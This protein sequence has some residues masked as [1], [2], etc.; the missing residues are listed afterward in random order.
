LPSVISPK[1]FDA[2]S[3]TVPLSE[4]DGKVGFYLGLQA[5]YL[6]KFDL[7]YF[8]YDNRANP[9]AVNADRLY[10]WHTKFHSLAARYL[11]DRHIEVSFHFMDGA[12]EM[13]SRLV[14]ADFIAAYAAVSITVGNN[15]YSVRVDSFDVKE[16][17]LIPRDYNDS[18]GHGI[19]ANWTYSFTD[20]W[21]F[22]VEAIYAKHRFENRPSLGVADKQSDLQGQLALTYRF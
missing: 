12:T 20:N 5:Q 21:Q 13:G 8:I 7:R 15:K 18:H 3:W 6:R 22:A 14:Y 9:L 17:D 2:P 11:I 16:D 10:A 19:T 1:Y 4:V